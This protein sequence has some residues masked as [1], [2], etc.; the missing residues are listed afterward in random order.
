MTNGFPQNPSPLFYPDSTFPAENREGLAHQDMT[1]LSKSLGAAKNP[2]ELKTF[3]SD[4]HLLCYI[5]ST[6]TLTPVEFD[7]L[8][9]IVTGKDEDISQLEQLHGWNTLQMVMKEAQGNAQANNAST[10]AP[11]AT[12]VSC[13]HCTFTNPAGNES[14][15]MCGLPLSG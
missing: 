1:A 4:F 3:L 9:K 8:C 5:Q 12:N 14:C 7:Q 11:A 6:D 13:R 10:S 15:E 2:A